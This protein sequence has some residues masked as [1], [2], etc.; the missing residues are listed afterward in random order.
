MGINNF[1]P[2]FKAKY[3][4]D[5]IQGNFTKENSLGLTNAFAFS[6]V[7]DASKHDKL[8]SF[9]MIPFNTNKCNFYKRSEFEQGDCS[10][11]FFILPSSLLPHYI[12]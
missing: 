5:L 7:I 4:E 11:S 6:Y 2:Y 9:L 12:V 3:N 1:I 8:V 10:K